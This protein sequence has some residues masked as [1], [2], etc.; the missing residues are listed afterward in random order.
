MSP[1]YFL[2]WLVAAMAVGGVGLVLGLPWWGHGLIAGLV[3]VLGYVWISKKWEEEQTSLETLRTSLVQFNQL[4]SQERLGFDER[5]PE[6]LSHK[7]STILAE[8]QKYL[9]HL[10]ED[11]ANFS[12]IL[13]NLVEGV[14]AFDPKGQV[15]FSNSSANR[16]LGLNA[17]AI[18]GRSLWEI[19]R[20]QDLA[21]LVEGSQGLAIQESRRREI[22]LHTPSRMVL[23]VYALPF[24]YSPQKQGCVLMLH[25]LTKLRRLE[26][27]RAEFIDNVAHELRTPLT[28]IVGYL[29][30]LLD[31]ASLDSPKCRKFLNVAHQNADRLTR[32]VNDLRSL[33]EIESGKVEL[34][35]EL[36]NVKPIVDEVVEMFQASIEAKHL[37][38]VN[39]IKDEVLAWA[40]RDRVTQILV[41]LIDN[42]IKY[43]PEG[44]T[45]YFEAEEAAQTIGL[46]IRDS[47]PGIPS[48]ELPRITERFYRVDRARSREEGGTGL[49]LSIVKHLVHLLEGTL[50][51]ESEVGKGTIVEVRLPA[52]SE[53]CL[54]RE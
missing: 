45:I 44:G 46:R 17:H 43:T 12:A 9:K 35:R 28:A 32:L 7:F 42:A 5:S 38:L 51:I 19:I 50:N 14:L 40:D 15:L 52:V 37:H 24:P 10:E 22:T 4:I 1:Q 30:T 54:E 47:G 11:R 26:Q 36:V 29:E 33:S 53:V 18:Q 16:I 23:E 21:E 13:E 27:V 48:H 25:D 49:G 2:A 20:N 31:E 34:R 39:V 3:L 6:A 41:N 8:A